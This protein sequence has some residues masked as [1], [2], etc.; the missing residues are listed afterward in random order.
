MD[1][2]HGSVWRTFSRNGAMR[3]KTDIA[4]TPMVAWSAPSPSSPAPSARR[5]AALGLDRSVRPSKL[6]H[7]AAIA[8]RSMCQNANPPSQKSLTQNFGYSRQL[9]AAADRQRTKV[10]ST[11]SKLQRQDFVPLN[12]GWKNGDLGRIFEAWIKFCRQN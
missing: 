9:R 7:R 12:Y 2:C 5:F 6:A 1:G 11:A 10:V 4:A 8:S 3:R